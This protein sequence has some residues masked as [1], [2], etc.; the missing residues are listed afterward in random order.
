MLSDVI[1]HII[2]NTGNL[3]SYK[4]F[5]KKANQSPS[6]EAFDSVS[7]TFNSYLSSFQADLANE[8]SL[9]KCV[10]KSHIKVEKDERM[11]LKVTVK[12]FLERFSCE[13]LISA[14][15]EVMEELGITVI[16]SFI[17]S[18]PPLTSDEKLT[19]D[20]IKP[21]WIE[22]EKLVKDS[23]ILTIGVSD[24]DTSELVELYNWT[25][26]KPSVNQVNLDSCCVMPPEMTAFARDNDIQLLTHNDPKVLLSKD[27]L[28]K[29]LEPAIPSA[30]EWKISY[31]V[32]Y[33]VVV[34]SR[35][36]IQNKGYLLSA[37]KNT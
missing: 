37:V 7:T 2:L 20:H 9:F 11:N 34:K 16:D 26:V 31:I 1:N 21:L 5:K 12:V 3:I 27:M 10:N 22:L 19:L 13:N 35:G 15:D 23:K 29:V 28:Q 4:E 14:V 24:L 33:S 36:I 32:R 30:A 8:S 18:L 17:L 6:D 25:Q